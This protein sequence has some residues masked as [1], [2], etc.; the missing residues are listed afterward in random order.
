MVP[1]VGE[2]L[3]LLRQ[4]GFMLVVV[5]NQSGIGRGYFTEEDLGQIHDKMCWELAQQGVSLDGIFYCPH[6]PDKGCE[7]R[8]PRPGLLLN[9]SRDLGIDL[10]RSFMI[11]DQASDAEAARAAGCRSVLVGVNGLAGFTP[12]MVADHYAKDIEEATNWI[13]KEGSDVSEG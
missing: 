4:H 9:A 11:G 12:D 1:G 6:H 7:C 3:S 10:T 2:A 13:I 5:T 8:K